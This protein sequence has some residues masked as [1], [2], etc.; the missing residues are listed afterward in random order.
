MVFELFVQ[1]EELARLGS[2]GNQAGSGPFL[3]DSSVFKIVSNS[4]W[5]SEVA[6]GLLLL[7]R[8]L[9]PLTV[10]CSIFTMLVIE[11]LAR[12]FIFGVLMVSMLFLFCRRDINRR[13]LPVYIAFLAYLVAVRLDWVPWMHWV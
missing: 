2:Y 13:L 9:W 7:F 4:A 12:E 8:M 10:I 5:I 1:P 3:I 6:L 11:F